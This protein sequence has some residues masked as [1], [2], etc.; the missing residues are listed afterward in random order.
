MVAALAIALTI[1]YQTVKG[2]REKVQSIF[3]SG[4]IETI[5]QKENSKV[6]KVKGRPDPL[7]RVE[8]QSPPEK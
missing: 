3:D 2:F 6:F 1:G 4:T 7:D 5:E 8:S